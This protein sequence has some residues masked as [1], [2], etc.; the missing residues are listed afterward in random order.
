MYLV[1]F[2]FF[3][4]NVPFLSGHTFDI[5][6][7]WS[8]NGLSNAIV[9]RNSNDASAGLLENVMPTTVDGAVLTPEEFDQYL[10]IG[11]FKPV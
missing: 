7:F 10:S 5:D 11:T 2:I 8:N 1:L 3:Y 4:N 9:A 6:Q